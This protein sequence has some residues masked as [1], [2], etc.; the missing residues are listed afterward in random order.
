MLTIKCR[1]LFN[2]STSIIGDSGWFLTVLETTS[3][4]TG[5]HIDRTWLRNNQQYLNTFAIQAF[6]FLCSVMNQTT[7]QSIE[8]IEQ[9]GLVAKW[10]GVKY[11]E[12]FSKLATPKVHYL[13]THLVEDLRKHTRT[14]LFEPIIQTTFTAVYLLISKIGLTD[15]QRSRWGVTSPTSL[16]F[17]KPYMVLRKNQ[18]GDLPRKPWRVR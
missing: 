11:R 3:R 9:F 15:K 10:F 5:E 1:Y 8:T 4:K 18:D 6:D 12:Y 2:N 13:E 17:R 16:M 14:G 7:I